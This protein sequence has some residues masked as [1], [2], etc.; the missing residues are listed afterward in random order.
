[1]RA[2]LAILLALSLTGAAAAPAPLRDVVVVRAPRVFWAEWRPVAGQALVC[3]FRETGDDQPLEPCLRGSGGRLALAVPRDV[4]LL[5]R[6][7][8]TVELR[9]WDAR[10]RLL[11]TG[12]VTARDAWRVYAPVAGR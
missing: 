11:A 1:M 7:G 10:G 6:P 5:V 4:G 9:A 2:L 8:D 12:R 3:A